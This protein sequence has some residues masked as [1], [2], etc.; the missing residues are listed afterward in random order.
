MSGSLSGDLFSEAFQVGM[1][2]LFLVLFGFAISAITIKRELKP[3]PFPLFSALP[4]PWPFIVPS[5]FSVI[6][7]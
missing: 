5:S 3:L 2:T 4:K 6:L 1:Q 7:L